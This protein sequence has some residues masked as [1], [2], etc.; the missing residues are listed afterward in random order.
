MTA[1]TCVRAGNVLGEGWKSD[2]FLPDCWTKRYRA[3]D[4]FMFRALVR[5]FSIINFCG[6]KHLQVQEK[7]LITMDVVSRRD[8]CGGSA[9]RDPGYGRP[10]L[11]PYL[12]FSA[13]DNLTEITGQIA[14][15]LKKD[16]RLTEAEYSRFG[17]QQPSSVKKRRQKRRVSA[18]VFLFS[19][20]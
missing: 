16:Y 8:T 11:L 14:N 13:I 17:K 4:G 19:T 2:F 12:Y 10:R 1:V 15:S 5:V 9:G 7:L 20:E 6:R 18:K 3:A